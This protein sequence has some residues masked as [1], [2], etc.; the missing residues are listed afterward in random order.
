M[1]EQV[2]YFHEKMV[3]VQFGY[4]IF[5]F[6]F[7]FGYTTLICF[8]GI[9]SF[10][11]DQ[12]KIAVSCMVCLFM[13]HHWYS[14]KHFHLLAIYRPKQL[15]FA[16]IAANMGSPQLDLIRNCTAEITLVS[17]LHFRRN[18]STMC[19]WTVHPKNIRKTVG[20]ILTLSCIV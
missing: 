17:Y 4:A 20:T 9:K 14:E 10:D 6:N 11:V 15:S 8:S 3:L 2:D 5:N 19:R 1:K 16:C 7:N 18:I 12:V 13:Q